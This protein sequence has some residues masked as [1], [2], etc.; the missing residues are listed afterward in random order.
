MFLTKN[1]AMKAGGRSGI[2]PCLLNLENDQVHAAYASPPGK[3]PSVPTE[4]EDVWALDSVRT[5]SINEKPRA[6]DRNLTKVPR[7]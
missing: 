2:N 5:L 7:S 3:D 1:H 6:L 4:Y